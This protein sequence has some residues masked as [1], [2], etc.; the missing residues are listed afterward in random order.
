MIIRSF[1]LGDVAEPS[2]PS[3]LELAKKYI[4][5]SDSASAAGDRLADQAKC[6]YD[7]LLSNTVLKGLP[8]NGSQVSKIA[9]ETAD[10]FQESARLYRRAATKLGTAGRQGVS[11]AAADYL[12]LRA[13]AFR[14]RAK[15]QEVLAGLNAIP[16]GPG[17]SEASAV[18]A[19]GEKLSEEARKLAEESERLIEQAAALLVDHE[20]EPNLNNSSSGDTQVE[21]KSPG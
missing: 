3:G 10:L 2:A 18:K 7:E 4:S 8:D 15:S 19:L 14:Q 1:H 12:S 6:K 11:P 20:D 21:S 17:F 9:Y 16:Y 5:E 13:R